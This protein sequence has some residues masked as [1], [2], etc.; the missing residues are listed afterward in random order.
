M[1]KKYVYELGGLDGDGQGCA[2]SEARALAA[3]A[4][5]N[6][7]IHATLDMCKN[8]ITRH[9]HNHRWDNCKKYT[10]EYELVFTSLSDLPG[11]SSVSPISRSFFKL[12]EMLHDFC[13]DVFPG[14]AEAWSVRPVRAAFLAEGPGGFMEALARFRA[15]AHSCRNGG[16]TPIDD[17]HGITLVPSTGSGRGVPAW[18]L[19]S[20][21]LLRPGSFTVH[22]G[23]DGTG[24]LYSVANID[25]FADAVGRGSCDVVTADGGFDFSSNF[26]G[27]EEAS[28]RLIA[29][30]VLGALMLQRAGGALILKVYDMKARAT[31][32]LLHALRTCYRCVRLIKPLTSRPANSEKYVLCCGF[33]GADAAA[34][35]R[36]AAALRRACTAWAHDS[37]VDLDHELGASLSPLPVCLMRDV[38]EFNTVY[39]ARQVCYISRTL[40]L[41]QE[42]VAAVPSRQT[43]ADRIQ[44]QL[45][46]S[47]R[48]CYKYNVPVSMAVIRQYQPL[49]ATA[50]AKRPHHQLQAHHHHHQPPTQPQPA[51]QPAAAPRG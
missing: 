31:I 14:G 37:N 40:L 28:M 15:S 35:V 13:D 1:V 4:A 49:I 16:V 41:I 22:Q 32:R 10:N 27:Q 19:P 33:H 20:S 34:V 43:L 2:A 8:Q 36:V 26:N 9:Y 48:W 12:W 29:C 6:D 25:H 5:K 45:H 11:L 39:I 3:L 42:D 21:Q 30:E 18:R 17:L 47:L 46:K 7:A 23:A 44:C 38:V 51:A 50:A 24:N